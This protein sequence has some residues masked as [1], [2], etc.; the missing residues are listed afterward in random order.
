MTGIIYNLPYHDATW[1]PLQPIQLYNCSLPLS[2]QIKCK[3]LVDHAKIPAKSK[4]TDAG[5]DLYAAEDIVVPGLFSQVMY[6]CLNSFDSSTQPPKGQATKVSTGVA[7]ELPQGQVGL[8][9]DRSGLGSKLIKVFGGVIDENYRGEIIVCL[10]NFSFWDYEI[11]R[12]DRVAQLL[13]QYVSNVPI[14]QVDNL[15]ESERNDSGFGSSGK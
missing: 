3:L 7:L 9:W 2:P 8:I 6:T 1:I 12:G 15:T 11:K 14:I 4:P 10:A 13:V 5:Y